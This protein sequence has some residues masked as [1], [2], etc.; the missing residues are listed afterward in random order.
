MHVLYVNRDTPDDSVIRKTLEQEYANFQV[1]TVTRQQDFEVA[2][3]RQ[4]YGLVISDCHIPELKPE[5]ILRTVNAYDPSLPVVF[6]IEQ[7]EE[8]MAVEVMKAGASGYVLKTPQYLHRLPY[9]VRIA[10]ETRR[11][12]TAHDRAAR[13]LTEYAERL[14]VA[15]E[16]EH[17]VDKELRQYA[18]RLEVLREI[19]QAILEI[20]SPEETATAAL[21]ALHRLIPFQ[22]ASLVVFHFK[23]GEAT[24]LATHVQG[25]TPQVRGQRLSLTALRLPHDFHQGAL[26]IIEDVAQVFDPIF[27]KNALFQEQ[28]HA[29]MMVPLITRNVL[30]GSLNIGMNTSGDF[31]QDYVDIAR[32]VA[33]P[34]AIAL[35]QSQFYARVQGHASEL[36]KRVAK[37]TTELEIATAKVARVARELR[38]FIDSANV[39]IVGVDVQGCITEWNLTAAK[40]T[41]YAKDE[42]LGKPL[43]ENFIPEEHRNVVKKVFNLAL[44]EIEITDFELPLQIKSGECVLMSLNASTHR[45]DADEVTGVVGVGQGITGRRRAE[46]SLSWESLKKAKEEAEAANRLKDEF[47]A[48]ISH[49]IRTPMNAILGFA[50]LLEEHETNSAKLEQLRII[51]HSGQRLLHII[52]DVL[53]FAKL[54]AGEVKIHHARFGFKKALYRVYQRF[55]PQAQQQQLDLR[56]DIDEDVPTHVRGDELHLMQLLGNVVHNALKFT[57]KGHVSLHCKYFQDRATIHVADTG[58]GIPKDKVERIF[59]PFEQV[60]ASATRHHGGAG[61]GLAITQKLIRLMGGTIS[62]KSQFGRGTT[63]SIELPLPRNT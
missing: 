53:D 32:E 21:Q 19:D 37:R 12:S 3:Q 44:D 43:M 35:Q 30:V 55:L 13:Q 8:E 9:T 22:H 57:R 31:P 61:L 20:R 16:L 24:I 26:R 18:R 42:V 29:Y 14:E 50:D 23:D 36:E 6:L 63:V 38:R 15:S 52:N 56:L 40:I 48:N 4:E 17:V 41:G 33:D 5:Y 59:A 1:R 39:P 51:K 28:I 46:E 25:A 54:E 49:E 2:L 47:L 45:N 58:S 7:G 11:L 34:I 62:L 27:T 10:F 60:D